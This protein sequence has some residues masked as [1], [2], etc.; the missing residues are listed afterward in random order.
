MSTPPNPI[1]TPS[2]AAEAKADEA[3][4]YNAKRRREVDRATAALDEAKRALAEA[5]D[6]L[7]KR[8]RLEAAILVQKSLIKEDNVRLAAD[9]DAHRGGGPAAAYNAKRDREFE[10]YVEVDKANA[11]G[12]CKQGVGGGGRKNDGGCRPRSSSR[13]LR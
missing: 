6:A 5:E 12:P 8:R 3:A 1:P 10:L 11:A 4:A 9:P 7:I 13:T 2:E